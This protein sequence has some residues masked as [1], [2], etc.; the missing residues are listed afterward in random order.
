[1]A[2]HPARTSLRDVVSRTF[3]GQVFAL[4]T[5]QGIA[6]GN[7]V[8]I[9]PQDDREYL[10]VGIFQTEGALIG[11]VGAMEAFAGEQGVVV[12]VKGCFGG[13]TERESLFP[14][15]SVGL[16]SEVD[17]TE[18]L[19]I[20]IVHG[21]SR[22]TVCRTGQGDADGLVGRQGLGVSCPEGQGSQEGKPQEA[23]R[24]KQM[25]HGM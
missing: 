15:T 1:M 7:T 6:E 4:L 8:V 9:Y 21:E 23:G 25:C 2:G 14:R 10:P 20:L 5:V 13:G 12:G 22:G 24:L 16:Q 18:H 3:T 19:F 11:A 17:V